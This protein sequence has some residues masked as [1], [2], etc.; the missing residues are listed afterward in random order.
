MASQIFADSQS[1]ST[2]LI[3]IQISAGEWPPFLGESLPNQ[4]IVRQLI[5]DVFFDA[6]YDVEFVF[7]P[8]SRAYQETAKGNYSATAVWMFKDD[9]AN[10][11]LYSDP[12]LNEQFVLFHRTDTPFNWATLDDL[13]GK[14]IGGG[15]GY[16]YGPMFDKALEEGQF[17]MLRQARVEQ[18]I[19]MLATSRIDLFIEEMS[20][21]NYTLNDKVPELA[22]Q[23]TFHPTP[24][25]VNQS[26]LLLPKSDPGSKALMIT[27]N[28][29]LKMFKSSGRY[30]T[31]FK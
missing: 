4:G 31:Y 8:W 22:D 17:E 10:D 27:F 19:Q 30:D 25:L 7:L 13:K 21:A 28:K 2:E 12:V 15:Q 9:R 6:G 1:K 11:F 29:H 5:T 18:N 20:V 26:F 23:I 16:S 24:V 14:L 3:D